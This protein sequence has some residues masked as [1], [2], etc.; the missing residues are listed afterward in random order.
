M[1]NDIKINIFSI[2]SILGQVPDNF[3]NMRVEFCWAKAFNANMIPLSRMME[4]EGDIA[5]FILPKK[6]RIYDKQ[7]LE[8]KKRYPQC[9][10]GTMQEGPIDYFYNFSVVERMDLFE[11]LDSLDFNLVHNIADKWYLQNLVSTPL[12]VLPSIYDESKISILSHQINQQG[13]ILSGSMCSWYGGTYIVRVLQKHFPEQSITIPIAHPP[14]RITPDEKQFLIEQGINIQQC[15]SW[16]NW[17]TQLQQFK[18]GINLM[19]TR[20]AGTFSLNCAIVG[21]PC[22]GFEDLDTQ[23]K[24]HSPILSIDRNFIDNQLVKVITEALEGQHLPK[25]PIEASIGKQK[26]NFHKIERLLLL[27]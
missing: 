9:K 8:Y 13:I 6:E 15:L 4:Y 22:I 1:N 23:K 12:F 20:A 26:I 27:S 7:I 2:N 16:T 10:V 24:Y 19:P 18:L 17:I 21:I 14:G 25:S 3:P 11:I 5:I